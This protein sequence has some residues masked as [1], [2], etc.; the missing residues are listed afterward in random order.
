[1]I[2]LRTVAEVREFRA[3]YE[4]VGFVPTM[5]ALHA[6]H[7]KLMEYA[8]QENAVGLGSIF[9]N[10]LQFGAGEDLGNYPR[11]EAEDIALAEGVG[12]GAMFCP[13][14][15][16]MLGRNSTRV[17]VSGVSDLFEGERRPGH[18]EGV[19]TIVAQLFGIARPTRAYFG[20]KDLQQ[21]AVV[22]QMVAD[23]CMDIDLRFIE[24]IREESGLA[25]SSRNGYFSESDRAWA[26]HLNRI[27]RTVAERLAGGRDEFDA[28]F[29]WGRGELSRHRFEV[30]YLDVVD[31]RTMRPVQSVDIYSRLVVAARFAGVRL[32]D[33]LAVIE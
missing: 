9:V 4:S 29:E 27:C 20:L 14:V 11:R 2:V 17:T 28:A 30:E 15:E 13:S 32:I 7:L 6:G 10:P 8:V 16:E 26:A 31:F 5:G 21:C 23:L 3:T 24:T 12:M 25:M 18:F 33:N 19:A 1:M 22:R